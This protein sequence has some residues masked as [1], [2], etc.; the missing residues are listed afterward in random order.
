MK[1]AF[2]LWEEGNE[3]KLCTTDGLVSSQLLG[4]W[5]R[6]LLGN[7][8]YHNPQD[9]TVYAEEKDT[10]YPEPRHKSRLTEELEQVSLL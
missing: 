1:E 9:P 3:K 5:A 10:G 2:L 4:E 6:R 8:G 7:V